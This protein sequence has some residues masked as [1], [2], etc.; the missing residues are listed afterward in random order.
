MKQI[1]DRGAGGE[2]CSPSFEGVPPAVEEFD[3]SLLPFFFFF[4][5]KIISSVLRLSGRERFPF[6]LAFCP[7][8]AAARLLL[9]SV[10]RIVQP[11]GHKDRPLPVI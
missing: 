10:S 3:R 7:S 8:W 1:E 6:P 9:F 4:L 5:A 11:L 2:S